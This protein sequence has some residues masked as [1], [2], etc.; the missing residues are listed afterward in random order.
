[1]HLKCDLTGVRT[2]NLWIT[3]RLLY[4]PETF[5]TSE[6]LYYQLKYE[7]NRSTAQPKFDPSGIQTNDLQIMDST[8]L[9]VN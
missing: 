1:M 4:G 6:P 3:E 9:F 7:L 2:H 5:E 8:P